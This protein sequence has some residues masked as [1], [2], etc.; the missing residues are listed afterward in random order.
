MFDD[1]IKFPL[2]IPEPTLPLNLD[3]LV[4][5]YQDMVEISGEDVLP[6]D[7]QSNIVDMFAFKKKKDKDNE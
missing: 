6:L 2:N 4:N 5:L 7:K 3:T 1:E